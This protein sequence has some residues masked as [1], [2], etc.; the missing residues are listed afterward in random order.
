MGS[1]AAEVC[2]YCVDLS[3]RLP[4]TDSRA[5]Q[6]LIL[7]HRCEAA[8]QDQL[9][10]MLSEFVTTVS[11]QPSSIE[12]SSIHLLSGSVIHHAGQALF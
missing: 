9:E 3:A 11:Q 6:C 2:V 12:G 1:V 7:H 10:V 8:L 4:S 5:T